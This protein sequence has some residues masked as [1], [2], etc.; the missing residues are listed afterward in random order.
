MNGNSRQGFIL[1]VLLHATFVAVVVVLSIFKP[2]PEPPRTVFE[3]VGAPPPSGGV[4]QAN[5]EPDSS[6]VEFDPLPAMPRPRPTPRRTPPPAA[7]PRQSLPQPASA[8][9]KTAPP[10][11]PKT[12]YEEFV[13]EHGQPKANPRTRSAPKGANVPRIDTRFSANIRDSVVNL[14]GLGSMSD[15]EQSAL[16][17]YIA[18][19]KEAL[20]RSWDKPAGLAH[21]V[22]AVVEFDVAVN[23]LL[24]NARITDSSGHPQFDQSVL[25]AFGSLGS[26]GPAPDGRSHQFRL[27][28]RMTDV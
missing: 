13:R 3:L 6:G 9:P 20:R 10:A 5:D 23:G 15:A 19:M 28:F 2:L 21:S 4:M 11:T 12:S 17:S 25:D 8:Q 18:R 14:E 16:D 7:A 26:A 22:S 1:S 27:T 24:L